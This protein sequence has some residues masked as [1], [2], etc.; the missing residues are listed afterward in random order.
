MWYPSWWYLL[1]VLNE[2]LVLYRLE[3]LICRSAKLPNVL[4]WIGLR[5]CL[6]FKK[7]LL[8][9]SPDLSGLRINGTVQCECYTYLLG[10]CLRR[11][12]L[13]RT[14]VRP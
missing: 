1:V 11:S 12:R 8:P 2:Y 14:G 7:T 3:H 13:I 6:V 9:I 4:V 10:T 5:Q